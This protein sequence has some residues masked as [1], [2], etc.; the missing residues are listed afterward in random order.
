MLGGS[1]PR[2]GTYSFDGCVDRHNN[3]IM[4]QGVN[5]GH[6][7]RSDRWL[8]ICYSLII[9]EQPLWSF[10]VVRSCILNPMCKTSLWC[11]ELHPYKFDLLETSPRT[12]N[13]FLVPYNM[14]KTNIATATIS[15]RKLQIWYGG[16]SRA[17]IC[18]DHV[19]VKPSVAVCSGDDW[20]WD[21][22]WDCMYLLCI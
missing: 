16:G 8:Q 15:D 6:Y 13:A 17:P 20:D 9:L 11:E 4:T 19:V 21:I 18:A 5:S 22:F 7:P 14:K 12:M 10:V 2:F 1:W 3:M